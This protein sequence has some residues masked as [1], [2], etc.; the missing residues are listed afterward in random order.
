MSS[1]RKF[2]LLLG[3]KGFGNLL[4]V[5]FVRKKIESSRKLI[6]FPDL[7]WT[8][9]VACTSFPLVTRKCCYFLG[10]LRNKISW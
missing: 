6:S 7:L 10:K 8:K 9:P 5:N 3:N 4:N 1:Y 2:F